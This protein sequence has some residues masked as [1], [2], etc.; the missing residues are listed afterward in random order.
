MP[1][2]KIKTQIE[3]ALDNLR[4]LAYEV[5]C[6][7]QKQGMTDVDT[8]NLAI[9]CSNALNDVSSAVS[10]ANFNFGAAPTK[11]RELP[12]GSTTKIQAIKQV[13][14][15]T[16]E[17]LREAKDM[18]D[19]ASPTQWS[20]LNYKAGIASPEEW[21]INDFISEMAKSGYEVK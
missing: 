2:P 5:N 7:W 8:I 12:S 19:N 18:V 13:R 3:T 11:I 21:Q 10:C 6:E 1:T 17:G 14:A 20:D 15:I 4:D 9:A 16:G